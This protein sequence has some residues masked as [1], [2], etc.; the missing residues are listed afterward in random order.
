MSRFVRHAAHQ[1]DPLK[2]VAPQLNVW[3]MAGLFGVTLD[4]AL[5]YV[6]FQEMFDNPL[7]L[8]ALKVLP[9]LLGAAALPFYSELVRNR[10]L[11][12]CRHWTVAAVSVL[13]ALPLLLSREPIF[14]VLVT[15]DAASITIEASDPKDKLDIF[16]PE[17]K[18]FRVVTPDLLKP[19]KIMVSDPTTETTTISSPMGRS[20]PF[21]PVIRRRTVLRG[22]LAQIPLIGRIFGQPRLSLTPLYAVPT[23][24]LK[25]GAHIVIGGK[26]EEGYI[27]SLSRNADGV[28]L[29]RARKLG[30]DQIWCNVGKGDDALYLPRGTYDLTLYRDG[31]QCGPYLRKIQSTANNT[32]DFDIPCHQ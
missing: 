16:E 17:D 32:I 10:I 25:E 13:I 23:H 19:Y 30:L 6:N 7:V 28:C 14:S 22:T 9:W 31:V 29:R 18:V 3:Q 8:L 1:P 4:V 11:S 21:S 27:D 2:Q 5:L 20:Q 26:F 15:V 12:L 24:S